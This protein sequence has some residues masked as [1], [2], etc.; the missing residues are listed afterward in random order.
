MALSVQG[1]AAGLTAKEKTRKVGESIIIGGLFIQIA[2]FTFFV[3]AASVF[4]VRMRK[5]LKGRSDPPLTVP[6][7]RGLHMIYACSALIMFRSIFRAVEYIMGGD[8][9]LLSTEW[10]IYALDTLPMVAVQVV[11]L[12]WFPDG[13]SEYEREKGQYM[14]LLFLKRNSTP[15]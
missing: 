4:H 15:A 12:V 11:F 8:G 13:F 6:W 9:Y 2:L 14:R 7:R 5:D 1:N 3:I 10:P